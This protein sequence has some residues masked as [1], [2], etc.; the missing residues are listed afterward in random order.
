MAEGIKCFGVQ[1]QGFEGALKNSSF[2]G[3]KWGVGQA[4]CGNILR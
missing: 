3:G 4:K 1:I 2:K